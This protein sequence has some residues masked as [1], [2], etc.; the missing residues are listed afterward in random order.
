MMRGLIVRETLVVARQPA[1]VLVAVLYSGAIGLFLAAWG[2]HR[3]AGLPGATIYDQQHLLQSLLL[4]FVMPWT[5]ARTIAT[6][7]GNSLVRAS[8]ILAQP[9]SRLV[10]ARIAAASIA[11][12]LV[13][14][15]AMPATLVAQQMSAV[16]A[17]RAI[18]G[19]LTLL[20]FSLP[21]GVL[22][23]WWMLVSRDRL[24]GWLGATGSTILLVVMARLI[25]PSVATAA[26]VSAAC[27]IAGA[28]VLANRAGIWWRYLEEDQA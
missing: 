15:T 10:M 21:A 4:V 3:L 25:V 9:P 18:A 24:L 19:Q 16:S 12:A 7:R 28:A 26:A 1:L 5:A 2:G 6:D 22:T 20:S 27:A 17:A 8:A 23:V 11:C 13:V 14:A